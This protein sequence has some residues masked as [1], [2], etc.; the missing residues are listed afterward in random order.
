MQDPAELAKLLG[1]LREHG[2]SE[3]ATTELRLRLGPMPLSVR[4]ATV[5]GARKS[6]EDLADDAMT[7]LER[8]ALGHIELAPGARLGIG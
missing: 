1:V 2:V 7:R 6:A 3:Y 8:E 4:V 5:E